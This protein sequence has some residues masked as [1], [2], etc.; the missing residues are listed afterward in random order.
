MGSW[1]CVRSVRVL[2]ARRVTLTIVTRLLPLAKVLL[3]RCVFCWRRGGL[4]CHGVARTGAG[5]QRCAAKWLRRQGWALAW[6]GCGRILFD[7]VL[8]R[9]FAFV[10]CSFYTRVARVMCGLAAIVAQTIGSRTLHAKVLLTRCA[11][12][13]RRGGRFA[14]SF[15]SLLLWL[16]H[17]LR[18]ALLT[19]C[20]TPWQGAAMGCS[21]SVWLIFVS[22]HVVRFILA[23]A[24]VTRPPLAGVL[25]TRCGFCWRR[26]GLHCHWVC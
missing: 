26:F 12:S 17:A 16:A 9:C 3:T 15:V 22:L 18:D 7:T 21:L 11:F 5:V 23:Q 2:S 20:A 4:H 25:L 1:C 19:Y 8:P 6:R 13:W 10:C 24:N 14:F